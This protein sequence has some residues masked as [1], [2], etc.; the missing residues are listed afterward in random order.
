M[1]KATVA[2]A[3]LPAPSAYGSAAG[4]HI[5]ETSQRDEE[6]V[7]KRVHHAQKTRRQYSLLSARIFWN[8]A[9]LSHFDSSIAN[10]RGAVMLKVKLRLKC[11]AQATLESLR[12]RQ[13]HVSIVT[14]GQVDM[15]VNWTN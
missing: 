5:V 3:P 11:Q 14:C 9:E 12:T 7:W 2:G 13:E 10:D 4:R 1:L 6:P 8:T 15:N